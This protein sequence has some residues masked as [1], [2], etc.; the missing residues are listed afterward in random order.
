MA[1]AIDSPVTGSPGT[2][3]SR[4][5]DRVGW[6]ALAGLIFVTVYPEVLKKHQGKGEAQHVAG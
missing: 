2:L 4:T 5:G 3:Y 6:L 1:T